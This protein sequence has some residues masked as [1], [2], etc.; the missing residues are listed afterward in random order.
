M[1]SKNV[2]LIEP[3]IELKSEFMAMA[4]EYRTAGMYH[5]L[6]LYTKNI[7]NFDDYIDSLKNAANGKYLPPDWVPSSTFWLVQINKRMIGT[8]RIRHKLNP[9]LEREGGH[10]GYEIRPS[11]RRKGYGKTI[12]AL[13][14][15]KAKELGIKQVL[16]TCD[17]DNIAS[18]RIIE[19][20]GGQLADKIKAEDSEVLTRRYWINLI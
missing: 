3:T 11:E 13:S 12:L 2:K 10:I 9:F 16:V 4:D 17:D 6:T 5:Y 18:V 7:E 8:I 19:K 14:L 20:N 15:E 1:S